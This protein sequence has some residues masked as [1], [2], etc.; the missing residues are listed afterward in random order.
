[1][2][3]E[4]LV[5]KVFGRGFAVGAGNTN[6]GEM[7]VTKNDISGFFNDSF[8]VNDFVRFEKKERKKEEEKGGESE[9]EE[10]KNNQR[11][12]GGPERERRKKDEREK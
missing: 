11:G 8:F 12:L 5:K 1:M 2:E 3:I 6:S 7:R 4:N 9:G 10:D